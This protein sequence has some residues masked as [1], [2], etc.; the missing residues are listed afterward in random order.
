MA[1]ATLLDLSLSALLVQL[2]TIVPNSAQ[3]TS[4][5]STK[6][7]LLA[8]RTVTMTLIVKI[9]PTLSAINA[10]I[11]SKERLVSTLV[12]LTRANLSAETMTNV[13]NS[14]GHLSATTILPPEWVLAL[15]P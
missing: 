6:Q 7:H 5:T 13:L 11:P 14:S 1:V 2:M 12:F 9:L 4:A 15:L 3:T 10:T 8:S